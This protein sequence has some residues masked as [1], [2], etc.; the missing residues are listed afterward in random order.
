[1]SNK[2]TINP[3]SSL[4]EREGRLARAASRRATWTGKVIPLSQEGEELDVSHIPTEK[5]FAAVWQ[6]SCQ[7]Y[8]F[9]GCANPN[10]RM[11]RNIGEV[12]RADR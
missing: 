10:K 4:K 7:A 1:M 9:A 5:R 6:L 8:S 2:M 3:S 11:K 12:R